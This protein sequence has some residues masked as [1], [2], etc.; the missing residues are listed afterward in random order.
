MRIKLFE[1]LVKYIAEQEERYFSKLWGARLLA[2]FKGEPKAITDITVS[3]AKKTKK[4]Y[5]KIKSEIP[6]NQDIN[7][8]LLLC[9]RGI[10]K[11]DEAS[12]DFKYVRIFFFFAG[13][14]MANVVAIQNTVFVNNEK[15]LAEI[16]FDEICVGE[17]FS[18]GCKEL[19]EKSD[20]IIKGL[21]VTFKWQNTVFSIVFFVLSLFFYGISSNDNKGKLHLQVLSLYLNR[22]KKE[23]ESSEAKNADQ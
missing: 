8:L 10:A 21:D 1:K 5:R 3:E 19:I 6:K 23:R 2:R 18:T 9:D 4:Y 16:K 13:L 15:Y 14:V 12:N 11:Y 7:D 20:D 22:L 17:V